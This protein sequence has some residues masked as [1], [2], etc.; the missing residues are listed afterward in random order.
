MSSL[1]STYFDR[2]FQRFE[3][4]LSS[5]LSICVVQCVFYDVGSIRLQASG[6][7][8]MAV[9]AEFGFAAGEGGV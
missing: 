1:G 4:L 2:R 7:G 9:I 5:F 6:E 3:G 8:E